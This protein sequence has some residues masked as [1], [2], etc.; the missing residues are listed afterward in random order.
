[1]MAVM[2]MSALDTFGL[3]VL[4]V[5]DHAVVRE[6]LKFILETPAPDRRWAVTVASSGFEALERLR[7]APADVVVLD[8]SM[9]GMSGLDLIRRIRDEFPRMRVLVLSM[10]TEDQYVLRAFRNGAHGYLGKDSAGAE[11]VSAVRKVAQGGSYV[12]PDVAERVIQLFSGQ[13]QAPDH[14]VLSDREMDV[15]RRFVSG[16]TPTDIARE[17]HMSGKPVSTHKSR[18]QEKLQLPSFAA[19]I[20][21]GIEHQLDGGA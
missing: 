19:M 6:G 15:L 13:A 12:T 3:Q 16:Q 14:S 8:L 7:A 10:H 11:L 20:R 1:M 21:Y 17:L 4:L 9:P 18:I 2:I 5:D